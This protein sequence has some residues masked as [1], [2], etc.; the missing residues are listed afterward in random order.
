MYDLDDFA[1]W[2]RSWGA[3]KRTIAGRVNV[4]GKYL[5]EHP[6]DWDQPETIAAWI[7]EP[8]RSAWTRC[9]YMS[10]LRS[11][12]DYLLRTGQRDTDP[13]ARV[14]RPRPP[15]SAP[16]PFSL[17]QYERIMTSTSSHPHVLTWIRLSMLAGLRAHEIAKMHGRNI[18]E[19]NI[20]VRGKGGQEAFVPT[21]PKLWEIAAGYPAD[22][23]WFPTRSSM[24]HVH[25]TTVSN[26]VTAHLRSL[27][28]IGT[29]HQCRHTY[30]TSL[31]DN[32]F[33]IRVVQEVMRHRSIQSTQHYTGV[34][35]DARIAAIRSLAA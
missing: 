3:S 15:H 1:T 34:S 8:Q 20:F 22:D 16:R 27:G 24:G 30:A 11:Y 32:G 26:A 23:W 18:T 28:I 33:N 12:C 14:K 7:G 21:H 9:T 2:Q 17:A 13:T 29:L 5:R 25:G 31:L 6:E 4:V 10:H 35:D 19:T